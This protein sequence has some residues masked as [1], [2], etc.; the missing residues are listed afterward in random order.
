MKY[1]CI[2]AKIEKSKQQ[3]ANPYFV[4]HRECDIYELRKNVGMKNY[5]IW[6]TFFLRDILMYSN[7]V[8]INQLN[9]NQRAVW[10]KHLVI[11]NETEALRAKLSEQ[12]RLIVERKKKLKELQQMDLDD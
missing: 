11:K 9:S 8:E 1:G 7:N 12:H 4:D 2:W 3:F 5:R 6:G 10:K